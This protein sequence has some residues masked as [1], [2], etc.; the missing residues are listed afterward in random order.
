MQNGSIVV[1]SRKMAGAG[2]WTTLIMPAQFSAPMERF[3]WALMVGLSPCAT[4]INEGVYSA[5]K[6][7]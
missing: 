1:S 5:E 7:D 4:V 2:C 3:M 6:E